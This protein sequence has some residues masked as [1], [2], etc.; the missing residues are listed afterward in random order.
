[1]R[2]LLKNPT[3]WLAMAVDAALF[4]IAYFLAY[5]LRFESFNPST[6]SFF[7]RSV[8]PVVALKLAVAI[9]FGLESGMWRYT[10]LTDFINIIKAC[11]VSFLLIMAGVVFFYSP[12]FAGRLSR[13]VFII[14]AILAA[15]LLTLFRL[16][17]RWQYSRSESFFATFTNLARRSDDKV[18]KPG[19]EGVMAVIYRADDRGEMLLRS[20]IGGHST[21]GRRY[22]IGGFID[23][24]DSL[25]GSSIHGYKVLGTLN[26]L[27][28]ITADLD[29]RELLVA[30]QVEAEE[31]ERLN[32]LCAGLNLTLQVVPSY[33]EDGQINVNAAS[34]RKIQ[35]EDLLA[36]EPVVIHTPEIAK[37]LAGKRVMVTGAGGSIGGELVRQILRYNPSQLALVDKSENYL[38]ELEMGLDTGHSADIGY[39]CVDVTHRGKMERIFASIHPEVIF[40]AAAHKH[41]PMMERNQ[42]EAILN[43]VGGMQVVAQLAE[44]YG[45]QR[46]ILI[47]TDKAVEP[48]NVM[49]ATK[50]ACELLMQAH[51]GANSKTQFTAVRFGNVL[52]SNGSVIP[53]FMSQIRRGGPVTVTDEKVTRYFMTIPEA[54]GLVLETITFGKQGELFMLDMGEPVNILSMAEK[55]IRLAG[56]EPHK[57]IEISFIGLRPGE[58][59]AES[60]IGEKEAS[61]P[62]AHPKVFKVIDG[63]GE[64]RDTIKT[65][66]EILSLCDA[67][68]EQAVANLMAWV[69]RETSRGDS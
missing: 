17:I 57:D 62:T 27:E 7:Y 32:D 61:Q 31:L 14:D 66:N 60:L 63:G 45:V 2:I 38:H 51:A 12:D 30:S 35:I 23:K 29:V 25:R 24:S 65:V 39:H 64:N 10:G 21:A 67:N 37:I 20:L 34:L 36:R 16:V 9:G 1:M 22:Q 68:P 69:N 19:R 28:K 50:R 6:A 54:V 43:N 55:M 11:S 49:G 18:S 59:Y 56:F 13:S 33:L 46:F 44:A 26:D 42:D 41:V 58:K 53:L 48:A 8:G 15:G 5:W 3:V 47:S 40:H 52:G 4:A